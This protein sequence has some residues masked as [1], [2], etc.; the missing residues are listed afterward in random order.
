VPD[1]DDD[2]DDSV[3]GG[4]QT[5]AASRRVAAAALARYE[6]AEAAGEPAAAPEPAARGGKKGG[7]KGGTGEKY[8]ADPPPVR[9][10][11]AFQARLAASPRQVMRYAWQGDPLVPVPAPA[12]A[13][14]MVACGAAARP[15]RRA[16][17][18]PPPCGRCGAARAFELQLLPTV[19]D[20]V[21]E[22]AAGPAA[23]AERAEAAAAAASSSSSSA[24][25]PAPGPRAHPLHA[26]DGIDVGSVAVF[27]CSASCGG[28]GCFDE[29][30]L[31]LPPL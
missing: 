22:T 19:A 4:A 12:A 15:G 11:L 25:A 23:G 1:Q 14:A 28:T 8:E 31:V 29:W 27:S 9:A 7:K 13:E 24:P 18:L 10:L 30:V 17:P 16:S 6:E 5:G 26:A 20:S 2:D 3:W 21:D